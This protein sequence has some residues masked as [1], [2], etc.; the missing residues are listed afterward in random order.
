MSSL[1][2]FQAIGT[3]NQPGYSTFQDWISVSM[4]PL[5]LEPSSCDYPSGFPCQP[6]IDLNGVDV[7]TWGSGYLQKSSI[8]KKV[9]DSSGR[10]HWL[11]SLSGHLRC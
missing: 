5:R 3:E 11:L 2:G 10:H 4:W 1:A 6:V 8:L 9:S 7:Q